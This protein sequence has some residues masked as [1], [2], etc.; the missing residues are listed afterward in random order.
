MKYLLLSVIFSSLLVMIA[1]SGPAAAEGNTPTGGPFLQLLIWVKSLQTQAAEH[2]KENSE[3]QTAQDNK[4][5]GNIA[6]DDNL[7]SD[8]E[9]ASTANG[10]AGIEA[11]GYGPSV[12]AGHHQGTPTSYE[13]VPALP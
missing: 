13:T 2:R 9:T 1:T 7:R 12:L 5:V 8:S 11:S 3:L 6:G 10:E 4:T